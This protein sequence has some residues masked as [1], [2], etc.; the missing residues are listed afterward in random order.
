MQV[1]PLKLKG[2]YEIKLKPIGDD[3]GFFM[4]TYDKA[5]FK[6]A[7]I[8]HEWKQENHAASKHKHTLR[9]LHFQLPP[10]AETKI[11]RCTRGAVLDVFVDL[12]EGSE[13][14]GQWDSVRLSAEEKNMVVVPKGFAHGYLTLEDNSEVTYKV[15]NVYH[16]ES[17]RAIRWNDPEIGIDWGIK[18]P[19]LSDKDKNAP[20]LQ[21][22]LE[23][24]NAVKI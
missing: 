4:R 10:Y 8:E 19:I 5:T 20:S 1:K 24:N 12:R 23:E 18:E 14:F 9:G 17:E 13:T 3:R 15:D 21:E 6:E 2:S 22:F 16:P 11:L 7:G